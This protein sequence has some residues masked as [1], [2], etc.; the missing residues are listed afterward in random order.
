MKGNISGLFVAI[1]AI[2]DFSDEPGKCLF[3]Y[4]GD[5][6]IFNIFT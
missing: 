5:G 4:S 3:K 2:S 1:Q 6:C